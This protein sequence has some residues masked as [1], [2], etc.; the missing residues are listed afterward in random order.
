MRDARRVR[1]H[2]KRS[3]ALAGQSP[4]LHLA[5]LPGQECVACRIY[6]WHQGARGRIRLDGGLGSQHAVCRGRRRGD[7]GGSRTARERHGRRCPRWVRLSGAGIGTGT[8]TGTGTTA[9]LDDGA[10][11]LWRAKGESGRSPVNLS[12]GGSFWD[13]LG[14]SA[15]CGPLWV[16]RSRRALSP[17]WRSPAARGEWNG[18]WQRA[19]IG[20]RAVS[21]P[22]FS[23]LYFLVDDLTGCG[24]GR[25]KVGKSETRLSLAD[26]SCVCSAVVAV[27][28]RLRKRRL[29]SLALSCRGWHRDRGG[30][31]SGLFSTGARCGGCSRRARGPSSVRPFNQDHPLLE[32]D[33]KAMA[34][35]LATC[36]VINS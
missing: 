36:R 24:R 28:Q 22:R 14:S 21:A 30:A 13:S 16:S 2:G 8:W 4:A 26:T 34:I 1:A 23:L 7:G 19:E 20:G 3:V 6:T 15:S 11:A 27:V 29:R 10:P 9:C 18:K 17:H 32:L 5:H 12:R 35:F 31:R 25:G 33:G